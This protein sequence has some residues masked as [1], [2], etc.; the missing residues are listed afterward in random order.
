MSEKCRLVNFNSTEAYHSWGNQKPSVFVS[1]STTTGIF[2]ISSGVINFVLNFIIIAEV[3]RWRIQDA[4]KPEQ[5]KFIEDFEE[6][7]QNRY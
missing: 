6:S 3:I 1:I 5:K 7:G 4:Y 2:I